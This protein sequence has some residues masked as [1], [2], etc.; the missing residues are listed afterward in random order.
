MRSS[1]PDKPAKRERCSSH[2]ALAVVALLPELL[3]ADAHEAQLLVPVELVHR[4]EVLR[5]LLL[6]LLPVLAQHELRV[7]RPLRRK[8]AAL[9]HLLRRLGKPLVRQR[10]LVVALVQHALRLVAAAAD[11][12]GGRAAVHETR[13]DGG[14]AVIQRPLVEVVVLGGE[15]DALVVRRRHVRAQRL[16]CVVPL[17]AVAAD[18][19]HETVHLT[20][21]VLQEAARVLAAL[22]ERDGEVVRDEHVLQV[23]AHRLVLHAAEEAARLRDVGLAVVGAHLD[24]ADVV[25]GGGLRRLAGLLALR[26][27]L[28]GGLLRLDLGERAVRVRRLLGLRPRAQV[29]AV[30]AVQPER[31]GA[32]RR[33]R[34]HRPRDGVALDDA[35]LLLHEML[36]ALHVR[37]QR[38]HAVELLVAQLAA[39]DGLLVVVLHCAAA[40][41]GGGHLRLALNA[42]AHVGDVEICRVVLAHLVERREAH[43]ARLT[44]PDHG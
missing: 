24:G 10:R 14:L 23:L 5:A 7:A 17:R 16:E 36:G 35:L 34:E 41:L 43:V 28:G 31:G 20:R 4:L 38:L 39:E 11:D 30:A 9:R 32:E 13:D 26:S 25:R 27:G 42:G 12:E 6:R 15:D 2:L 18:E 29:G 44:A 21:Q 19:A 40:E 33:R 8:Q 3:D 1:T 37:L 22:L